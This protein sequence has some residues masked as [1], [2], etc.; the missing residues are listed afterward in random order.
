ME[1]ERVFEFEGNFDGHAALLLRQRVMSAETP[2]TIL[3]FSHVENFD[4]STLPLLTVNLVLLR[5]H[6]CAVTLRGLRDH[7]LRVLHHFGIEVATD[8]TVQV[9]VQA[10]QPFSD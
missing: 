4:D 7:Q 6:G 10:E 2:R 5:R 1:Q 9:G 8:G 3:D